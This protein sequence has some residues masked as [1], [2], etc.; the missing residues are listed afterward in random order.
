MPS[1][2]LTPT[3]LIA[4]V[5]AV[6]GLFVTQGLLDNGTGQ[7]VSGLA[8]VLIPLAFVIAESIL[9]GHQAQASSRLEA[10]QITATATRAAHV[11]RA[12]AP[13]AAK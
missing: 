2:A 13:R 5:V 7:L 8:V 4:A 6:V 9:K 3:Y 10:A 12:P 11:P 1:P